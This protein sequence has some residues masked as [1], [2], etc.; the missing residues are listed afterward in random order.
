MNL[1]ASVEIL[2][3]LCPSDPAAKEKAFEAGR[4][5]SSHAGKPS[6]TETVPAAPPSL[7]GR[8]VLPPSAPWKN[9]KPLPMS[10]SSWYLFQETS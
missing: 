8:S 4:E 6:L 2:K 9:H 7:K 1:P 10:Y 5:D 3:R